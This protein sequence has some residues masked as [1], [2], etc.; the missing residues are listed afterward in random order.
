MRKTEAKFLKGGDGE[1]NAKLLQGIFSQSFFG[2]LLD[3]TLLNAAG[4]L[5][6]AGQV[7]DIKEGVRR[8]RLAI[9]EG[10]ASELLNRLSSKA[11]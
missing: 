8:A 6:V 2:P 4:A 7:E 9:E 5:V 11:A 3:C 10:K 1:K